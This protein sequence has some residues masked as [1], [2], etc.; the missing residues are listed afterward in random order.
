VAT[1]S[2]TSEARVLVVDDESGLADLYA[3]WLGDDYDVETAYGGSEA[4]AA[5]G[6]DTD[7]LLLD[8]RMPDMHGDEVLDR[9]REQNYDVRVAMVTAVDP[10]FDLVDMPCDDYLVKSVDE[11][12]LRTTV[13]RLL[14]LE[15]LDEKR[16]ALTNKQ[17]RRN[18]LEVEKDDEELD[19]SEEFARLEAEIADL[20][21]EVGEMSEDLDVEAEP[22]V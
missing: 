15:Q 3:H 10:D 21:A 8:R 5:V 22:R 20:E 7:V 16:R 12:D 2:S 1:V 9:V 11:E 6:D 13:E 19:A 4:L 14:E 18:L 17:I